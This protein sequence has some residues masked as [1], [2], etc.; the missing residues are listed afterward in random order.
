MQRA[1][2]ALAFALAVASSADARDRG[3]DGHFDARRSAHFV[4]LQDV[5]IDHRTGPQ[6]SRQFERGVLA[7]LEA[8]YDRLDDLLGL[9]PRRPIEVRIYDAAVFDETFA[10]LFRFPAAGFYRGAIQV[11]GHESVS[12]ALVATLDHELVHAALEAEAPDVLL[13]AWFDEGLAEWFEARAAGRTSLGPRARAALAAL[14][15]RD[16]LIPLEELSLPSLARLD[17]EPAAVA[18]LQSYAMVDH[19][20]SLRGERVLRDLLGRLARSGDL[21]LALERASGLDPWALDQSLR[22]WLGRRR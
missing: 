4:L 20:V 14:A 18:Y 12:P 11:R 17:P 5:A 1:L 16:G 6:G 2:L 8:G 9:R 7:A 3:A 10:G 21:E 13:P 19:L 22:T 15:A